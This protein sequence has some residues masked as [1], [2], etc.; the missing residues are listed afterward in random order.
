MT[1]IMI[2]EDED[3]VLR[4]YASFLRTKGYEAIVA[5][6]GLEAVKLFEEKK[7]DMVFLDYFVPELRGDQIFEA[8]RKINP[9]VKIFFITGSK[10]KIDEMK[11][12]NLPASGFILKPLIF[13]D[14]LKII[15][16][17]K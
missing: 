12:K 11:R 6:D 1:K 13:D 2:V 15:E 14:F 17:N 10:E 4:T 16:E 7:P 9:A 5:L 3:V 8:M